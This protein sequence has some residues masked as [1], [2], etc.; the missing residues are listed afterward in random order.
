[1]GCSKADA[2]LPKCY[3]NS[4]DF[5]DKLGGEMISESCQEKRAFH[6]T[7]AKS[8]DPDQ[9][10][11]QGSCSLLL[12]YIGYYIVYNIYNID[13]KNEPFLERKIDWVASVHS[14]HQDQPVVCTCTG[15]SGHSLF[16]RT[17]LNGVH[18]FKENTEMP[19][20]RLRR[21]VYALCIHKRA[22]HSPSW[23]CAAWSG[24][25]NVVW[26]FFSSSSSYLV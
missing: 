6:N 14:E 4:L 5:K 15:W 20:W 19:R 3:K 22:R 16:A 18:F 17:L 8:R 11:D 21:L 7:H 12:R 23:I 9:K 2:L 10:A 1:M 26:P 13:Y 24:Y 25:L